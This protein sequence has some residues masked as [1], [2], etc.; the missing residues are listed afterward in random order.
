[1]TSER[2]QDWVDTLTQGLIHHA[3]QRAPGPLSERLEEEWLADLAERHG[4]LS[5]LRLSLGCCWAV[6]FIAREQRIATVHAASATVAHA[7]FVG[8]PREDSSRLSSRSATFFVVVA[9][10]VAVL[11]G[12]AVGLS[13]HF[14]KPTAAPFVTRV[15]ERVPPPIDL[16]RPPTPNFSTTTITLPPDVEVPPIQ[17]PLPLVD[18]KADVSPAPPVTDSAPVPPM[19]PA[20]LR[21]NGSPGKGFP[22][23]DDF[24][25]DI[26]I[27]AGAQGLATVMA[28]VDA[29]GRLTSNPTIVQSSGRPR[30]DE[31]ALKLAKAGS[32]HYVASTE[33]GRPVSACYPFGIRFYLRK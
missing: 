5:R 17:A 12:L 24:Y 30:L 33:D 16:P 28:C 1:M 9:L 14:T 8:Y 20:V 11:C 23:T 19:Q 4:K 21:L 31:A 18:A 6:Y 29:K 26:E 27:R 2:T 15:I 10:H 22:N 32:G 7:G 25:P 13:G 3:A